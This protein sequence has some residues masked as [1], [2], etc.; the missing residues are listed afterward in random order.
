MKLTA[1]LL[2]SSLIFSSGTASSGK[3]N[4]FLKVVADSGTVT[5]IYP[6][7]SISP[8]DLDT[9]HD[10][11]K[12]AE[13]WILYTPRT[14]AGEESRKYGWAISG[15]GMIFTD[16]NQKDSRCAARVTS[17]GTYT[18]KVSMKDSYT[19]KELAADSTTVTIRQK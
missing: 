10:F 18:L 9:T 11:K 5:S 13:C 8:K 7:I 2:A 1:L 17:A 16:G 12:I 3:G 14:N 15:D 4:P 19:N 6:T